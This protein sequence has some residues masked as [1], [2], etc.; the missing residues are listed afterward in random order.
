MATGSSPPAS[1]YPAQNALAFLRTQSRA[2][3][4]SAA[5]LG[6]ADELVAGRVVEGAEH[7]RHVAQRGRPGAALRERRGG[8]ALEVEHHPAGLGAQHL[9]Q[10]VVAVHALHRER[11]R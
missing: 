6:M 2:A 8:L 7:P 5:W 3:S 9:A 11:A 1:A 4:L 10:V